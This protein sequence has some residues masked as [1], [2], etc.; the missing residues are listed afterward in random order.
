M[1]RKNTNGVARRPQRT[2]LLSEAANATV[3][4]RDFLRGSGLAI[5]GLAAIAATGGAVKPASAAAGAVS[6]NV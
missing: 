1:L 5:G 6:G 3:D 2:T 4:R